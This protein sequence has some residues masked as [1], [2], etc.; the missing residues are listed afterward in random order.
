MEGYC[1]ARVHR[2]ES[3][4]GCGQYIKGQRADLHMEKKGVSESPSRKWC[5]CNAYRMRKV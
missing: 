5:C 2:S 3:E 1:F 4:M